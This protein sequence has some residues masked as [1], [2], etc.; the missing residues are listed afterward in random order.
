[1]SRTDNIM[2]LADEKLAGVRGGMALVRERQGG[3]TRTQVRDWI[4]RLRE[5]ADLLEELA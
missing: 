1:M 2:K 4:R 5:A 3:M